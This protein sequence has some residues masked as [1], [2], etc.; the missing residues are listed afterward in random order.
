MIPIFV[1]R[2][3][4][5]SIGLSVFTHSVWSRTSEPVSITPLS[6]RTDGSNAFTLARFL[7]PYHMRYQGFAIWADGSDMLCLADIAELWALRD[8]YKAVQVVKHDYKTRHPVK[9]LGQK[10]YDY[11]RKNW[12]SLMI[13][14]CAH[15]AWRDRIRPDNLHEMSGEVLHR[16]AFIKDEDVGELPIEWNFITGEDE[17]SLGMPKIVHY[18]LGL[19]VWKPYNTWPYA[20]EWNKELMASNYFQPWE[21]LEP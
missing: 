7:I 15:F 4:R 5:E 16:F 14:N 21:G 1:G 20:K 3:E 18:S 2:D 17:Q 13:I 9:Y 11:P 8:I 12:S 10:N 6:A 19:P